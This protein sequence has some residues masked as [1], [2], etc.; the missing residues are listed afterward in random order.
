MLRMA[1]ACI[2]K[3]MRSRGIDLRLERVERSEN[4][5]EHA[6]LCGET[7]GTRR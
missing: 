1:S 4:A 2:C 3:A 6:F 7:I 5:V